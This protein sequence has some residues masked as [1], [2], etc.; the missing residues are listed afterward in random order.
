VRIADP[1]RVQPQLRTR[2]DRRQPRDQPH[3][4]ERRDL[5]LHPDRDRGG[6]RRDSGV[7]PAATFVPLPEPQRIL[8]TRPGQATADGT[9]VAMGS[10]PGGATLQLRTAGRVS[11]PA[12]ASAAVLNVTAVPGSFGFITVHPRGSALPNASNLNHQ[13]GGVVANAVIARIGRDGDI[14]VFTSGASDVIVDV[15]GWLTGPPPPTA[16][17]LC[18]SLTPTDPSTRQQLVARPAL[19]TAIGTD[20]HRRARV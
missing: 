4:D 1:E 14:C 9:F 2:T 5:H 6:D 11:I 3:R 19:H 16:G 7:L 10:Q 12:N 20:L 13:P 15:A 8:D 17:G 18:P